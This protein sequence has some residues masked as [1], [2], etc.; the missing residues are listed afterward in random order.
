MLRQTLST[1]IRTNLGFGQPYFRAKSSLRALVAVDTRAPSTSM[2]RVSCQRPDPHPF[3]PLWR[4]LGQVKC[5]NSFDP[6]ARGWSG[7]RDVRLP[8]QP[9]R[10]LE[11]WHIR[12]EVAARNVLNAVAR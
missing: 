1:R 11:P 2:V 8:S 7:R 12:N 10:L 4:I 5:V 3:D 6:C 9:K